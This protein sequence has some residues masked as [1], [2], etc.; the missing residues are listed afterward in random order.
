ME[1]SILISI[2]ISGSGVLVAVITNIVV[3]VIKITKVEEKVQHVEERV[4]CVESRVEQTDKKIDKV[5][6]EL[7][8][9]IKEVRRET[10]AE[11]KE[12]GEKFDRMAKEI[13]FIRGAF[14]AFIKSGGHGVPQPPAPVDTTSGFVINDKKPSKKK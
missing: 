3:W 7:K 11:I 14:E 2:I 6:Q 5:S 12:L 10:K 8:E 9:E 13:S 4:Q 1:T